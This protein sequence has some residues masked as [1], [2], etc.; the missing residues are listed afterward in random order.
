MKEEL[1]FRGA[2]VSVVVT[3]SVGPIVLRLL[4]GWSGLV[5]ELGGAGAWTLSVV[6]HLIYALVIGINTYL[7]LRLLQKLN[8]RGSLAGAGLSAAVTA[9]LVNIASL[10]KS[11]AFGFFAF[12]LFI[13][14]LSW[15]VNFAVFLSMKAFRREAVR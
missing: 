5:A 2:V 4:P 11:V 15:I 13:A 7:F 3:G 12:S 8:H 6:S 9:T 10:W 1:A 14:W